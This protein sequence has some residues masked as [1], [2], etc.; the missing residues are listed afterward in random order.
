MTN[1]TGLDRRQF[2]KTA[3]TIAV[4][5][6]VVTQSA[7]AQDG[8]RMRMALLGCGGQGTVLLT[9]ALRVPE[10]EWVATC[11]IVEEAAQAA[12]ARVGEGCQAFTRYEDVLA[13]VELD[14]V[15]IATPLH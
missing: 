9:N 11:D 1:Q 6:H 5:A 2:L 15:A 12:A 8:E 4:G 13:N 10:I 3:A 14:A 7:R